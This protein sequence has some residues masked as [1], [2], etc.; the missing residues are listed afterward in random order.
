MPAGAEEGAG[1]MKVDREE[2]LERERGHAKIF[3]NLLT[4]PEGETVEA[5]PE[6]AKEVFECDRGILPNYMAAV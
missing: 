1:D 3:R 6:G 4:L 2:A 5:R